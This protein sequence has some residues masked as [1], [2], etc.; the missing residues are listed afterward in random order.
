MPTRIFAIAAFLMALAAI[1]LASNQPPILFVN[2][3]RPRRPP[4]TSRPRSGV[5]SP[6]LYRDRDGRLPPTPSRRTSGGFRGGGP[7]VGK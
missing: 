4:V 3:E 1:V 7:G 5:R 6:R 2:N